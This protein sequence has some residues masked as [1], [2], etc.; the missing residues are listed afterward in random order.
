MYLLLQKC[1]KV[2]FYM[3]D[4]IITKPWFVFLFPLCRLQKSVMPAVPDPKYV[5]ADLFSDHNGNFQVN[6]PFLAKL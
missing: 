2:D 6:I 1:D 5:F 4:Y 3:N